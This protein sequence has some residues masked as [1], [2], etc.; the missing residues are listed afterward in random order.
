MSL[1]EEIK[2]CLFNLILYLY[3]LAEVACCVEGVDIEHHHI[4]H[5]G[6]EHGQDDEDRTIDCGRQ[7]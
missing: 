4:G 1:W 5:G 2:W 6:R 3:L 7:H